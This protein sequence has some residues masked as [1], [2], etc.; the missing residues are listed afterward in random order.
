M[1]RD[2]L[3]IQ[4][5][6]WLTVV[7]GGTQGWA[8]VGRAPLKKPGAYPPV[9]ALW[10]ISDRCNSAVVHLLSQECTRTG[11]KYLH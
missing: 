5:Q 6:F 7:Q 8:R 4:F 3:G 1:N 9:L 2:A 11:R 10:Q